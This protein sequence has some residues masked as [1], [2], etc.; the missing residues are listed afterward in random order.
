MVKIEFSEKVET[1]ECCNRKSASLQ[2]LEPSTMYTIT[3]VS[4]GKSNRM[5]ESKELKIKTKVSSSPVFATPNISRHDITDEYIAIFIH[6]ASERNGPIRYI[7]YIFSNK[8]E[9]EVKWPRAMHLW[10]R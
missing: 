4:V 2:A 8:N 1:V 10:C 3:I 7:S 9:K 6:P 5:S